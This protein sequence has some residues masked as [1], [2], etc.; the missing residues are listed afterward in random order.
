MRLGKTKATVR[1]LTLANY[2]VS[3]NIKRNQ[4]LNILPKEWCEC[5]YNRPDGIGMITIIFYLLIPSIYLL[6]FLQN[7]LKDQ[8]FAKFNCILHGWNQRSR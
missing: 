4:L 3:M 8:Q 5:L 2:K 1:R 6:Q 7:N